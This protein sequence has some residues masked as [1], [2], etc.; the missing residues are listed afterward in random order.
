[1]TTI[2]AMQVRAGIKTKPV[3]Y[4]ARKQKAVAVQWIAWSC[5]ESSYRWLKTMAK[6]IFLHFAHFLSCCTASVWHASRRDRTPLHTRLAAGL[7]TFR[8]Y[9]VAQYSLLET[10]IRLKLASDYNHQCV[11]AAS[12]LPR[13]LVSG[14]SSLD[15]MPQETILLVPQ[16]KS[17]S[18]TGFIVDFKKPKPTWLSV[19]QVCLKSTW[20]WCLLSSVVTFPLSSENCSLITSS[21]MFPLVSFADPTNPSM[22]RFQCCMR[23][24]RFLSLNGMC[25]YNILRANKQRHFDLTQ[26]LALFVLISRMEK[27]WLTG[28]KQK[29]K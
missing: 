18:T 26:G 17:I 12:L 8:H 4:C 29:I 1:M 28:L 19:A 6:I 23:G 7:H 3:L 22:D 14:S 16:M 25:I 13:L 15:T 20:R 5:H 2:N 21:Q 10:S 11:L 9:I 24:R 27:F